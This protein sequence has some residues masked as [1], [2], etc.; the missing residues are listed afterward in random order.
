M[1][2]R[3]MI[4]DVGAVSKW[5]AFSMLSGGEPIM[6]QS[7]AQEAIRRFSK[8]VY[9]EAKIHRADITIFAMDRKPYWRSIWLAEWYRQNAESQEINESISLLR[10]DNT[11]YRIDGE[12][13]TKLK[14]GELVD[15]PDKWTPC[16]EKHV[17]YL[18]RYKGNRE[19]KAWPLKDLPP[20]QLD[21]AI[22]SAVKGLAARLNGIIISKVGWEAD[23][24]AGVYVAE[25]P[26]YV[27]Q[28]VLVTSDSDW[29]QLL[30]ADHRVIVSDFRLQ[31]NFTQEDVNEQKAALRA[32]IVGG[33]AGDGIKGLPKGKSGCFGWDAAEKLTTISMPPNLPEA[34]LQRNLT[35]VRLPCPLWDKKEAYEELK[36]HASREVEI[37]GEWDKL[38]IFPMD[39]AQAENKT[40]V[41][42]WLR[43]LKGD[44]AILTPLD[45]AIKKME[46]GLLA[47][48]TSEEIVQ[49]VEEAKVDE[50]SETDK[51]FNCDEKG[52]DLEPVVVEENPSTM[53]D[54]EDDE[55]IEFDFDMI[56]G[57]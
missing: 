9:C 2:K 41:E 42:A 47:P 23:D 4:V 11:T 33:D 26:A 54:K 48:A 7:A 19:G 30:A 17:P 14:V 18:P 53:P 49:A 51:F 31:K 34:E 43:K 20:E 46:E 13:P 45:E 27:D 57:V 37:D 16:S 39:M 36:A 28:I 50:R 15:L 22:T 21:Q 56:R 10:Y 12:T 38:Y 35:L 55:Q 52:N 3:V 32:K 6:M 29:R 5:A 8:L 24:I 40:L 44:E 1:G 25:A